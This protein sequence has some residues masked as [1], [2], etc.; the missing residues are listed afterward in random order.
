MSK[1][2]QANVDTGVITDFCPVSE[3]QLPSIVE[4]AFSTL[5]L[6]ALEYNIMKVELDA[7]HGDVFILNDEAT[8]DFW[9]VCHMDGKLRRGRGDTTESCDP[10]GEIA[11][12]WYLS[13]GGYGGFDWTDWAQASDDGAPAASSL[14]EQLFDECYDN[15]VKC[16]S[17]IIERLDLGF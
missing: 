3:Q 6:N 13:G 8:G 1:L 4:D 12:L 14:S 10:I 17:L 5:S 7:E 9:A 11:E 15:D 2:P 16:K